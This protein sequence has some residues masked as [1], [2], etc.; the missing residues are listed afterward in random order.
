[1]AALCQ[2]EDETQRNHHEAE[3]S[4]SENE[5]EPD[6][7]NDDIIYDTSP[8]KLVQLICVFCYLGKAFFESPM[9]QL[10]TY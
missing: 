5:D 10:I 4:D 9:L 7:V 8:M 3:P 6:M 1:M 2:N